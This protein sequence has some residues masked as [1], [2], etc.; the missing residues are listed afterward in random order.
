[1][2]KLF[3]F[4]IFIIKTFV[5]FGFIYEYVPYFAPTPL[6]SSRKVG[7]VVVLL[8]FLFR[9]YSVTPFF[10]NKQFMSI[11]I[12]TGI[13]ILYSFILMQLNSGSG[14]PIIVWYVYFIAYAIL[15]TMLFVGFFNW[16]YDKL[17]KSIAVVTLCQAI[18][19]ILTYYV[20]GIRLLNSTLFVV[21]EEENIDFL[22]MSRLRSI[23]AAGAGLSVRLAL[24]SFSFLYLLIKKKYVVFCSAS[25][26]I[27]FFATFLSGTTGVLI[28]LLALP[29]SL[30]LMMYG[31]RGGLTSSLLIVVP[32]FYF[33]VNSSSFFDDS[34]Y[35]DLTYKLTSLL[36]D[37]GEDRTIQALT[38]D[39]VVS[40]I[41]LTTIIGT[42]LSRGKTMSGEMCYHDGG[43]VRNYF[44]LGLVMSIVFYCVLYR[45]MYRQSK[46]L[47]RS[48]RYLLF[49]YILVCMII[50]F[51]EPFMFSYIPLFVFQIL[52]L[53]ERQE[54]L[55]QKNC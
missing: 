8:Y 4:P 44:G 29:V 48:I 33:Y 16:D 13:S 27:C 42:G 47:T 24:S 17:I 19:C 12:I 54:L 32:L 1:M 30:Y 41:S 3:S 22:T 10:R 53:A 37:K 11:A 51:K 14:E 15:G 38:T 5:L 49:I 7:L 45:A 9:G 35:E 34:Q 50:E 6:L 55:T 39:Q 20:D 43:Y 28:F 21:S 23:G 31:R 36:M 26:V 46:W 52:V 40:G 2:K 25:L 18:W